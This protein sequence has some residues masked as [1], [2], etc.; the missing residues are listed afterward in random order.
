LID[1]A[2]T[3]MAFRTIWVAIGNLGALREKDELAIAE[4]KDRGRVLRDYPLC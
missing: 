3:S 4:F 1:R 2:E